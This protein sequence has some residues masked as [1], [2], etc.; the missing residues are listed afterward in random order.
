MLPPTRDFTRTGCT[1]GARIVTY[2]QLEQHY[3]CDTCGGAIVHRMARENDQAV[4]WAECGRC[5][6]RGFVS[7]RLYDLQCREY[8]TLVKELPPELATLLPA[9]VTPEQAVWTDEEL[10]RWNS[11]LPDWLDSEKHHESAQE[12]I[13]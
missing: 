10:E 13:V 6:A 9:P 11:V 8:H 3:V 5:K 7:Q 1:V 2:Q 4:D 12:S